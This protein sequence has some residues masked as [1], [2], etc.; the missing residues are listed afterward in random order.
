MT[1]R[2]LIYGPILGLND[3]GKGVN[4]K[5]VF[6]NA[7]DARVKTV[8]QRPVPWLRM[9]LQP[10]LK[11]HG[12]RAEKARSAHTQ[13]GWQLNCQPARTRPLMF[14][15]TIQAAYPSSVSPHGSG[16]GIGRA[17]TDFR[18]RYAER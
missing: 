12:K 17:R 8:A 2:N 16:F 7:K 13:L 18:G 10:L 11:T 14:Q 5:C 15:E 6:P 4:G 1:I 9:M 3:R